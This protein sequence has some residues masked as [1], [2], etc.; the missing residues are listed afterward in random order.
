MSDI[1]TLLSEAEERKV[2]DTIRSAE[3]NT[4]GEIRV[5]MEDNCPG[6]LMDRAADIFDHLEITKTKDRNGVLLYFAVKDH[7]VAILGDKGINAVVDDKFWDESLK[8]I[9]GYFKKGE[10]QEG[11][12]KTVNTVGVKLKEHF[13]IKGDD[14]NELPDEISY[15]K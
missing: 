2:I 10:Y 3:S 11:I 13:P 4:S 7:K 14:K 12:C 8:N 6:E 5:H 1:K 9:I 15:E